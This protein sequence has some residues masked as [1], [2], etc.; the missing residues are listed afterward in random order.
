MA[1]EQPR[2]LC[3]MPRWLSHN[4]Y[5]WGDLDRDSGAAAGGGHELGQGQHA[6]VLG[7]RST[8]IYINMET[9]AVL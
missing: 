8:L 6:L 9:T 2:E 7:R 3:V 4:H 1:E 5:K